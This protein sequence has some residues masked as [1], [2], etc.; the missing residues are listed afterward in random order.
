MTTISSDQNYKISFKTLSHF[1]KALNH[2]AK[3]IILRIT[4]GL[5]E[6]NMLKHK[7]FV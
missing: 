3:V 7:L 2:F 6:D 5:D 4:A 1:N